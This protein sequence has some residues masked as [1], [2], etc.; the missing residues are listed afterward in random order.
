[1]EE[2]AAEGSG[3]GGLSGTAH[4][5]G[6]LGG[7]F[8]PIGPNAKPPHNESL[9]DEEFFRHRD[10]SRESQPFQYTA[11][12]THSEE[13]EGSKEA[14]RLSPSS[15]D[16]ASADIAQGKVPLDL[17]SSNAP[18]KIRLVSGIS[19]GVGGDVSGSQASLPRLVETYDHTIRSFPP[20]SLQPLKRKFICRVDE[21]FEEMFGDNHGLQSSTGKSKASFPAKEVFMAQPLK[22]KLFI[23]AVEQLV[24]AM[25]NQ[26]IFVEDYW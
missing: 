16:H 20:S 19:G 22:P 14:G 2:E 4:A 23:A 24:L 10:S 18:L 15:A 9:H 5:R 1:M 6:T 7:S 17:Q 3:G 21:G 11:P 25:Q 8:T 26:D 12:E 13:E